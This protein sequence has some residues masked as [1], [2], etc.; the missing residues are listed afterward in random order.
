MTELQN[1]ILRV[2][3]LIPPGK[4]MSYGQVAAY[5]GMPRGAR[6]IGWTLSSMDGMD[7]PWWRVL[8]NAG[9]ITIRGT[10][11]SNAEQQRAL[12]EAEGVHIHDYQLDMARYRFYPNADQLKSLGLDAQLVQT[13]ME[14]YDP[15]RPPGSGSPSQTTLL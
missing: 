6:Q 15:E 8:N 2:V 1:T 5:L 7:F 14:K 11:M 13:L 3:S 9:Q 12:L 10:A 4:V